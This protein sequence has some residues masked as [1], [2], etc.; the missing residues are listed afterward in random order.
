[1]LFVTNWGRA[2]GGNE[3]YLKHLID[4]GMQVHTAGFDKVSPEL[5]AKFDA[6]VIPALPPVDAKAGAP[7]DAELSGSRHAKPLH[8]CRLHYSE[9]TVGDDYFAA[10]TMA[11][12]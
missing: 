9:E 8:V 3:E 12:E 6:V 11:A 5:L 7:S 2:S 1:V 10:R 4:G